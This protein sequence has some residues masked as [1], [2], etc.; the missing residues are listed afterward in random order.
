MCCSHMRKQQTLMPSV[1][2][3]LSE[4]FYNEVAAHATPFKWEVLPDAGSG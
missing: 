1:D 4:R 3:E 2:V